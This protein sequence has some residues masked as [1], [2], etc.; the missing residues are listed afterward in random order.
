MFKIIKY[1]C[2]YNITKKCLASIDATYDGIIVR[3]NDNTEL[4]FS[5]N[6]SPQVKAI[7]PIAKISSSDNVILN[8]D[9]AI[10][11][12]YDS[13]LQLGAADTNTVT[14]Q[15]IIIPNKTS[16]A[17]SSVEQPKPKHRGGRPKKD[18]SKNK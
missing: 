9:N 3:L 6:V 13:V 14:P 12:K 2:E 16:E 11:G 8:L 17:T 5:M 18:A 4:R 10:S 15:V 1:G 7:I